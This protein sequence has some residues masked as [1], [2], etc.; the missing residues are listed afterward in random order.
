LNDLIASGY[1]IYGQVPQIGALYFKDLRGPA[2]V[3][4]QGNTPDGVIDDNDRDFIGARSNPSVNYGIRLN[5]RYKRLTVMAFG[6]GFAG[7]QR[8][9]PANNR[10]TFADIGNSSHTQWL[11]AWTPDSPNNSFPRFGSPYSDTDS[12][13]WMEDADFLR[14]KNLNVGYD[15]PL[16]WAQKVGAERINLFANGTNL[17]MIY[18]KIKAFD[19]ET[20]GRGIPVNKT[21]SLGL[22]VTF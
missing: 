1:T 6:Q 20:S 21:Y 11:N 16:A 7:N 8:Y 15:I 14:L 19:P 22:N 13:F 10:F 17:F 2:A 12:S 5:L 9:Q 4:P 3:D 18:S